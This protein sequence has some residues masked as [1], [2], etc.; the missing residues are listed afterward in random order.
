MSPD[1]TTP[2]TVGTSSTQAPDRHP[3]TSPNTDTPTPEP[4]PTTRATLPNTGAPTNL[5]AKIGA[6][7]TALTA[8]I[9]L[10]IAA[11][12]KAPK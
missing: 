5:L 7:L 8:G 12:R 1:T 4:D 10:T 2:P 11:T 9:A 6:A 3:A